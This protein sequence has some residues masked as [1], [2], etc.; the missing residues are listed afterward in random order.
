M[1][2]HGYGIHALP[3]ALAFL[4]CLHLFWFGLILKMVYL[5][6]RRKKSLYKTGDIREAQDEE[7]DL[8]PVSSSNNSP[9]ADGIRKKFS[10]EPRG[11]PTPQS[12]GS[13]R[14]KED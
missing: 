9:K 10:T 14:A 5:S 1:H 11:P 6:V 12:Q 4:Q 3:Y 7:D 8:S 2:K 13:R